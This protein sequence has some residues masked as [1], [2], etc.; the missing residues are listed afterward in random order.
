M[1]GVASPLRQLAGSASSR[2]RATSTSGERCS[3]AHKGRTRRSSRSRWAYKCLGDKLG[4]ATY[5]WTLK[6][7][8]EAPLPEKT[9]MI[10]HGTSKRG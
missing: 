10:G 3:A 4:Y 1:L 8:R 7:E 9:T 5:D 6:V 2:L